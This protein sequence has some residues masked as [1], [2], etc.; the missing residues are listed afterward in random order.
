M[1]DDE[2]ERLRR[3]W[4]ANA[5]AWTRAVRSGAIESR[6][7]ATDDA[8]VD[9]VLERRPASVL[10]VGCG[11]GWLAHAL[12]ERGVRVVGVDGSE[13]LI[14]TASA[15]PG[16]EFRLLSYADV[17]DDPASLGGPFDAVVC[18]F[19]LLERDPAPLLTAL[20]RAIAPDGALLV[21]TVHPWT[22]QGDAP[23]RDGWRTET[24]AGLGGGFREPMPWYF[25][26]LESWVAL[27]RSARYSV[28]DLREP[29]HPERGD[30]LS[31]LFVAVPYP[32]ASS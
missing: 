12:A 27:L 11:E 8:I 4:D 15:R 20:R 2:G 1:D 32:D 17:A 10:D 19:A 30:P 21:Q 16:P 23:Y 13:G 29:A 25:R 14:S 22:A 7:V 6:R 9:A 28:A 18:N 26:T 3:S 5:D 24:F 31:L